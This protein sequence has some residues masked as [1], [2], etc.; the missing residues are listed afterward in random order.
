MSVWAR[1]WDRVIVWRIQS[2][3]DEYLFRTLYCKAVCCFPLVCFLRQ[4]TYQAKTFMFCCDAVPRCHP[5]PKPNRV[6]PVGE[7]AS[8]TDK[9]AIKRNIKSLEASWCFK[10]ALKS[11][12][13]TASE[14]HTNHC[15]TFSL[16][17]RKP[18]GSSILNSASKVSKLVWSELPG[19]NLAFMI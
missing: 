10:C 8:N 11:A 14:T 12:C 9:F 4:N 17:R 1:L 2:E 13:Q 15:D 6:F 5:S 18:T 19:S 3:C 16:V 7:T